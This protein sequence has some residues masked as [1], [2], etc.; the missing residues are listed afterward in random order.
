MRTGRFRERRAGWSSAFSSG[1]GSAW[2]WSN[3]LEILSSQPES[4]GHK[5][6][7][8]HM[9]D[10]MEDSAVSAFGNNCANVFIAAYGEM[11]RSRGKILLFINI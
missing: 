7:K 10:A 1:A 2:L 8:Q 3:T 4:N 5:P 11:G 9:R 6:N